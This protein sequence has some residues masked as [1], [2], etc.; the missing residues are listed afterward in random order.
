MALSREEQLPGGGGR[1]LSSFQ[2]FGPAA[3]IAIGL[4]ACGGVQNVET[5]KTAAYTRHPRTMLAMQQNGDPFP[6]IFKTTLAKRL[7]GCGVTLKFAPLVD[8]TAYDSWPEAETRLLFRQLGTITKTV[9]KKSTGQVVDKFTEMYRYEFSLYD[10]AS[11][12]V[13]WSGQGD[14]PTHDD[15]QDV[16]MVNPIRE[17]AAESWSDELVGL[18]RK[19]GLLGSCGSA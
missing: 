7:A 2:R 12:R 3:L 6:D 19:D 8:G 17:H 15:I 4:A 5:A 14:F 18:M 11:E 1:R 9:K 16:H 13:V 10:V